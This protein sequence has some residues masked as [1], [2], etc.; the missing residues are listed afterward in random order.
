MNVRAPPSLVRPQPPAQRLGLFR[1]VG[2]IRTNLHLWPSAAYEEDVVARSALLRNVFLINPPDAI[3]RVLV[4]NTANYRRSAVLIRIGSKMTRQKRT[5]F[6]SSI[7]EIDRLETFLFTN[8]SSIDAERVAARLRSMLSRWIDANVKSPPP[9]KFDPN[10]NK[11]L[12]K[13]IDTASNSVLFELVDQ[14][15]DGL[16]LSND[17]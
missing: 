11:V 4:E 1:F 2:A 17:R 15:L 10:V 16:G 13:K 7:A 3:R 5:D 8:V 14:T 12:A 9:L 6:S